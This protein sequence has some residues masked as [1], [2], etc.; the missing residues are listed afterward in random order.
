M[1]DSWPVPKPAVKTTI[2]IIRTAIAGLYVRDVRPETRPDRYVTV[3]LMNSAYPNPAFTRPRP[4]VEVWGDRTITVEALSNEV[5]A[6][7]RNA[8]GRTYSDAFV[9]GITDLQGP[10]D[11][12]DPDI[13][14]RLRWQIH[15]DLILSTL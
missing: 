3:G 13:T 11:Y 12:P 8:K 9:Y 7:I 4:L 5:V 14:D 1:A 2:A 10:V 15:F 6:A